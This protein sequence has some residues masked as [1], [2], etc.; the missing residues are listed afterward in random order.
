MKSLSRLVSLLLGRDVTDDVQKQLSSKPDQMRVPS[1]HILGEQ[2]GDVEQDLKAQSAEFLRKA[3]IQC[4]A[5]LARVQYGSSNEVNVALLVRLASRDSIELVNSGLGRIFHQ[6][7]HKSQ[8]LDIVFVSEEE[9]A[10]V[11]T[12]VRPFYSSIPRAN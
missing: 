9:E 8:H 5:Y 10:N 11:A 6:I 12:L 7:F 2:D 1:V 4:R 3:S